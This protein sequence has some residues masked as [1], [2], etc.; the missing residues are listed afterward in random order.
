MG[1]P[2]I[3]AMHICVENSY[4]I[5]TAFSDRRK[6]GVLHLKSSAIHHTLNSHVYH[7]W[8]RKESLLVRIS[9][10]SLGVL[11]SNS[12]VVYHLADW[13]CYIIKLDALYIFREYKK[14]KFLFALLFIKEFGSIFFAILPDSPVRDC[15]YEKVSSRI[16]QNDILSITANLSL[17]TYVVLIK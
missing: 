12:C 5:M 13:K 9:H 11:N 2:K 16:V 6:R 15:L 14:L 17:L 10:S 4:D 1:K 8:S 7:T 3:C